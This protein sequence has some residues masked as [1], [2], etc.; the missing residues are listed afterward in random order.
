MTTQNPTS[1]PSDAFDLQPTVIEELDRLP[2]KYRLPLVL[3][4]FEGKTNEE[5]AALLR[6]PP[7]TLKSNLSRGRDVLRKRLARRGL[8]PS[9]AGLTA[10][11]TTDALA[12]VSP[13]LID[14]N[15]FGRASRR[16]RPGGTDRDGLGF[17]RRSYGR[18]VA[19]HVD[20][21]D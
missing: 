6:C 16:G 1:P 3:C 4:Y 9:V 13:A 11:L 10:A 21:Q 15:H 7:G 8:A 19:Y 20:R 17:R 18:N 12:A 14:S 5:A 2:E